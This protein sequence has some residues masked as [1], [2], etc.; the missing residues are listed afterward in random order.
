MLT[1]ILLA[2]KPTPDPAPATP[3]DTDV[4]DTGEPL[5]TDVPEDTD[6][7]ELFRPEQLDCPSLPPLPTT[8]TAIPQLGP[9]EDFGF[10][11]VGRLVGTDGSGN[12]RGETRDGTVSLIAPNV[13][14]AR[15]TRVL[16]DGAVAVALPD[17]ASVTVVMPDGQRSVLASVSGANGIGVDLFGNV[18]AATSTGQVV[19][20]TRDGDVLL[21]AQVQASL[22]G[23][24]F[25]P[26]Y[27]RLYFNSEFGDVRVLDIDDNGDPVGAPSLFVHVPI[28]LA[29]IL[30]G[31]T[32]DMCGNLYVVRMDGRVYR[33]LPDGT[34][35]GWIPFGA[36]GGFQVIP[37]ANFGSGVGG[38]ERDRLY[39]MNFLG[40]VYE[41][42]IGIEGRWE[43]HYAQ[44]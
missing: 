28:S 2:C 38:F 44:P 32:T 30:D 23:I 11:A 31:M 14:S 3:V 26:D 9:H 20:M 13:G 8:F 12:L 35:D 36:Q 5:D 17:E 34:M 10:D 43:P 15:G 33:Y 42:E 41:A 27:R 4:L 19:R 24:A 6:P 21:A 16:P 39:A 40:G 18:W 22:D 7:P 29:A 1:L 25:S 37:A